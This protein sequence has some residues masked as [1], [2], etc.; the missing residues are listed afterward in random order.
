MAD[1]HDGPNRGDSISF[2]CLGSVRTS[3]MQRRSRKEKNKLV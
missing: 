3:L 1:D 2:L